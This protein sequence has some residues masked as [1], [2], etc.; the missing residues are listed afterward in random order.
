MRPGVFQQYPPFAGV[1]QIAASPGS[2][3]SAIGATSGHCER[4]SQ[5]LNGSHGPEWHDP[6]LGSTS[7]EA[8]VILCWNDLGRHAKRPR[9]ECKVRGHSSRVGD[10]RVAMR[11]HVIVTIAALTFSTPAL[12]Q[13]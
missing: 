9:A 11:T 4:G 12:A 8:A 1:R 2:G 7:D 3:P 10:R 13:T 6:F 5:G